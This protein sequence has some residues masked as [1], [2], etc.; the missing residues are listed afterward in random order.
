MQVADNGN[1]SLS[2]I[3][4]PDG[5]ERLQWSLK[6]VMD[7]YDVYPDKIVTLEDFSGF[8]GRP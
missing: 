3:R 2:F 5:L 4:A 8:T 1:C 6:D 7:Y